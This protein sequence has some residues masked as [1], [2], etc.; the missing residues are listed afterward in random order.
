MHLAYFESS[1]DTY[2]YLSLGLQL[3]YS[4]ILFVVLDRLVRAGCS[5]LRI[6]S[7]IDL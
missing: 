7:V 5:F 4:V 6:D 1:S 2:H 3:K